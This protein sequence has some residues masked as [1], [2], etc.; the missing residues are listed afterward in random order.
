MAACDLQRM[1][2]ESRDAIA[3]L[4]ERLPDASPVDQRLRRGSLL[5]FERLSS[6]RPHR[7][8]KPRLALVA[9]GTESLPSLVTASR[10][11]QWVARR[12]AVWAL[13]HARWT[14]SGAGAGLPSPIAN[15]RSSRRRVGAWALDADVAVNA[16]ID[17]LDDRDAGLC[18]RRVAWASVRSAIAGRSISMA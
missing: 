14:R 6:S 18:D 15:R 3:A 12:N 13:R 16:L 8:R 5:W 2:S 7:A 11:P 17:A 4:V 10:A 1:G 9:I